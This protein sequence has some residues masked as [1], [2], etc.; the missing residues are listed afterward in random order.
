MSAADA[1]GAEHN[2]PCLA[3]TYGLGDAVL[4]GSADTARVVACFDDVS[5]R[6]ATVCALRTNA[7]S[8]R[9]DLSSLEGEHA[10][11]LKGIALGHHHGEPCSPK[12]TP[13]LPLSPEEAASEDAA[14]SALA[15]EPISRLED[16]ESSGSEE[17][18]DEDEE[19]DV[20]AYD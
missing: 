17:D 5:M 1:G 9:R 19:D 11:W 14:G 18:D 12:G 13:Y 4:T 6:D 10:D 7:V 16:V 15:Q 20:N 8:R 3:V 2:S